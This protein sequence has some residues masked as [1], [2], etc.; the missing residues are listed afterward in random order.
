MLDSTL[1][2][3]PIFDD[4]IIEVSVINIIAKKVQILLILKTGENVN[5]IRTL[6]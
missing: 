4:I 6:R 2:E 5:K 3:W 1:I